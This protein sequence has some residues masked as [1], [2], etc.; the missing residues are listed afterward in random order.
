MPN[1]RNFFRT[2]ATAV[3]GFAI[4]P[5]AT[6][7]SRVWKATRQ[8]LINPEFTAAEYEIDFVFN[9]RAL[10]GLWH[11]KVGEPIKILRRVDFITS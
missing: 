11:F 6:T 1:R 9:E 2:L 5:P 8:P 4:L 10:Y 3:A 7:Y